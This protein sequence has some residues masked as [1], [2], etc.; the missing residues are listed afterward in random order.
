MKLPRILKKD[1]FVGVDVGYKTVK[2][3]QVK[4][5]NNKP[6][7]TGL[8]CSALENNIN[9]LGT[10]EFAGVLKHLLNQI[11][12]REEA[13]FTVMPCDQMLLKTT[14]VPN[15]KAE[16]MET[17]MYFEIRSLL[18]PEAQDWVTRHVPLKPGDGELGEVPVLLAAAP[19]Q[20]AVLFY[21][22]FKLAGARLNAIDIQPF[23]LWRLS[24]HWCADSKTSCAIMNVDAN[25]TQMIIVRNGY[26]QYT[27]VLA[28]GSDHTAE[29]HNPLIDET[30]RS[31]E[32][33]SFQFPHPVQQ[34]IVT[35]EVSKMKD[36][37]LCL[38]EKLDL[39][40]EVGTAQLEVTNRL[41][42]QNTA[43]YTV[44]VGLAL[45]GV[46]G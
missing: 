3:A 43:C 28:A 41:K 18:P 4:I 42:Q 36:F 39:P 6:V 14:V 37:P 38:A 30:A 8:G 45:G 16:E 12:Y 33:Y 5:Q 23:A 44:A 2:I 11:N 35:G 20:R 1:A 7:I 19:R 34:I 24:N 40:V 27:R 13:V 25:N 46:W 17:A 9:N 21:E 26:I 15:M 29:N 31:L 32:L 10:E 22:A